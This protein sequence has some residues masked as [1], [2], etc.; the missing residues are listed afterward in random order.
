MKLSCLKLTVVLSGIVIVASG[1][2]SRRTV[3][4]ET[5]GAPAPVVTKEVVVVSA[6][7]APQVE[8][9]GVAPSDEHVW[10]AGH[11]TRTGDRWTWVSGQWERRP[12]TTAIYVPGH[13]ERKGEGYIWREGY[14][15]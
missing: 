15:K 8:V 3:V 13:W 7:P 12:S 5:A 11:W 6:P 2:F 9:S 14:W 10:I 4:Y 1:C